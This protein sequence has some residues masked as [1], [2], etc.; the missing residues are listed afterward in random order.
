MT[1]GVPQ[2]PRGP[3]TERRHPGRLREGFYGRYLS[4][5]SILDIGFRGSVP[6]A[7][8]VVDRAIGVELDY[9]GYDGIHLPFADRSQDTVYVSHCLEHIVDHAAALAEWY[10]VLKVDGFLLIIVP[11]RYLYERKPVLPSR[12]NP[13]HKRFYTSGSLLMEVEAALPATGFRVRL[14]QEIDA[15]FDYSRSP[16]EHAVGCY[17]IELVVQKIAIPAWAGAVVLSEEQKSLLDRYAAV[18]RRLSALTEQEALETA[19]REAAMAGIFQMPPFL[20]LLHAAGPAIQ[21]SPHVRAFLQPFIAAGPFDECGYVTRYPD[22]QQAKAA[23]RLSDVHR[24]YIMHG[25]FEGRSPGL[26]DDVWK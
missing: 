12:F 1:V 6:D 11:H 10:R 17:E 16:Y 22:L 14:L 5:D 23:D 26:Q 9:P 25:Y 8:P 13:D 7:V 18:V 15:G 21:D 20:A 3:G 4:G 19:R 2:R 24:H